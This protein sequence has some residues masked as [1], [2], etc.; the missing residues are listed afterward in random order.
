MP[1]SWPGRRRR[2]RTSP[3]R[4]PGHAG[5]LLAEVL[6][7]AGDLAAAEQARAATLAQARD[8]GDLNSL[9]DLLAV[10]ADLDLRA[11]R[12]GDAAAHLREAAQIALQTGV[13]VHDTERPGGLR[14]PVRR[15]RAPRRRHH[16]LGRL[17][18]LRA[19]RRV[20]DP[21]ADAH[22][23][24]DALR[25]AWQVLGPDRARAAETARRGD[26]PGH[27]GRVRPDADRPRPAASPGGTG[28]GPA[29]RPGTGAGHPG[30]P[31]P[32]RRRR[33][34]PSCTSA[35]APSARTWTGSG[36]RP[37]AAAAPT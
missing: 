25:D 24:E 30:R 31:G 32:H 13:L 16:G 35:S 8:A 15:D 36:T 20:R 9:G 18:N 29:Q 7:E 11:G 4:P 5:Y 22:R 17:G 1:C 21:D 34:P 37:A 33:S 19:A 23:R 10:M 26:E 14:T 6:A 3:A 28:N 27:R 12:T 2:S